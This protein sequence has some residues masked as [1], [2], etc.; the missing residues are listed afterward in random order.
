MSSRVF[1]RETILDA[2]V[3]IIPLVIIG[4]F[5]VVFLFL[6][7]WQGLPALGTYLQIGLMLLMAVLLAVV[8]YLVAERI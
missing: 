8:T 6:S 2:L 7:P 1:D 3:N 4:F 5:I